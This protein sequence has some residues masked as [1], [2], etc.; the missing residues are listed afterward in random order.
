MMDVESQLDRA[1]SKSPL[2]WEQVTIPAV[3]RFLGDI[4]FPGDESADL[5]QGD[6]LNSGI[7]VTYGT[8]LPTGDFAALSAA[9]TLIF[10]RYVT[11]LK[12][13]HN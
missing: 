8:L 1:G 12:K 4:L 9:S 7:P 2:L 6:K 13:A 5:E 11:P 10:S 3:E